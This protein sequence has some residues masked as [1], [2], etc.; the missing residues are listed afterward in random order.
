[1]PSAWSGF[2]AVRSYRGVRYVIHVQRK[3]PGNDVRLEV[4][5]KVIEG[6][7]IPLPAA[8]TKEVKVSAKVG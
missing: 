6:T 2:E 1:M 5:G 7:V 3:G 8:G 4:D